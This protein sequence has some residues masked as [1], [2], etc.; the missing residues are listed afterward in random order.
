MDYIYIA[1]GRNLAYSEYLVEEC[2]WPEGTILLLIIQSPHCI[3]RATIFFL[4]LCI[5][6]GSGLCAW[7]QIKQSWALP[8]VLGQDT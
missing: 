8:C 6:W 7:L 1:F 4:L 2:V 3:E 5:N